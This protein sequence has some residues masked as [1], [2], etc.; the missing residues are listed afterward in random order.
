MFEQQMERGF[1]QAEEVRRLT[2]ADAEA[3][4]VELRERLH[5]DYQH[6]A[7]SQARA[8]TKEIAKLRGFGRNEKADRLEQQLQED[9]RQY[10]EAERR[11]SLLAVR[12]G[13]IAGY[14][15]GGVWFEGRNL[16][17]RERSDQ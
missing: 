8:R 17:R 7:G 5:K 10:D 12:T 6:I 11:K 15:M 4:Y 14:G 3:Q 1:V 2:D 9:D 16:K 13:R